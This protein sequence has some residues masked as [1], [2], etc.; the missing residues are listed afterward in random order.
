MK[1][2][3]MIAAFTITFCLIGSSA[4]AAPKTS[5][6]YGQD[7]YETASKVSQNGWKAKSNY[8]V[9]VS[10]ENFP[11]AIVAAPLAKKYNAPIL[12]TNKS[13]INMYTSVE[14]KRLGTKNVFLIGQKGVI[15]QNVEDG[16]KAMGIKVTRIGGKDRYETSLEVAK[17]LGK[18][19]QIA[20]VNGTYFEDAVSMAPIA[21]IKEMPILLVGKDA[22]QPDVMNYIN[23]NKNTEQIYVIGGEDIISRKSFN[24]IPN[25]KRIGK[26][27]KYQRNIDII[28]YFRNELQID[29]MFLA[30]GKTYSDALSGSSLAALDRGFIL[31]GDLPL[32]R[33]TLQFLTSEVVNNLTILGGPSVIGYDLEDAAKYL[34]KEIAY[35]SDIYDM[36]YQKDE[37]KPPKSL[38][39]TTSDGGKVEALVDWNVNRF[40]TSKPGL[41]TFYGKVEG[42]Y[43][44]I[45][46]N[47]IIQ[48][49]PT[50]ISDVSKV[51]EYRSDFVLPQ[52]LSANMSDGTLSD[53][54]VIWEYASTE[55]KEPGV[56]IFYGTVDKYS[57]KVKL[58]L[59]VTSE[60]D[61]GSGGDPGTVSD[62]IK[63]EVVQGEYYTLPKT[64]LDRATN[65]MVQVTWNIK[66]IDT[67]NTG[68]IIA[69]GTIK[70]S[71]NKIILEIT[72]LPKIV[73]I[74]ETIIEVRR[75]QVVTLPNRI[76]GYTVHGNR[77]Y[78]DVVWNAPNIETGNPQDY[79]INGTVKGY[80]RPVILIVK[81]LP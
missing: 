19:K 9:I 47:L 15:S 27:D 67:S 64:V 30:S 33:P 32:P 78:V 76:E 81:V 52:K 24:S 55:G 17:K 59:K 12:L 40:S 71:N 58:T 57:K 63:M 66:S 39:A 68:I 51:V 3:K 8:A 22:I 41:F 6:I 7:R 23:A 35:V 5:R 18:P 50:R 74:P 49:I 20:V 77:V 38:I 69:E 60:Y 11:D 25:A 54:P 79:Y 70:D 46:L 37:Y 10:G 75:G 56:Y 28:S 21:A 43:R 14:L 2:N 16:L 72:V 31:L 80:N 42:Y 48:P 4:L 29:N 45:A 26:G 13:V 73:D 34:P 62:Y 36:V 44:E 65:K 61:G 53:L 1:K